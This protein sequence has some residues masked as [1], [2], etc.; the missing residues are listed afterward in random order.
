MLINSFWPPSDIMGRSLTTDTGHD[1]FLFPMENIPLHFSNSFPDGISNQLV[2]HWVK[3][4][5]HSTQTLITDNCDIPAGRSWRPCPTS[6]SSSSAGL[7]HLDLT[8]TPNFNPFISSYPTSYSRMC[9][10]FINGFQTSFL[11]KLRSTEILRENR[12]QQQPRAGPFSWGGEAAAQA[13]DMARWDFF[14]SG[15]Y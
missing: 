2:T 15:D 13:K 10:H 6:C 7:C 12:K 11:V 4:A 3:G 14:I 5:V 1:S 8:P 9:F